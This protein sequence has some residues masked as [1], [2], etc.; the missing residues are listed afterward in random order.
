MTNNTTIAV[1]LGKDITNELLIEQL[2]GYEKMSKYVKDTLA[3]LEND[4]PYDTNCYQFE[5][6]ISFKFGQ[7]QNALLAYRRANN[8]FEVG[9]KVVRY[10]DADKYI[11]TIERITVCKHDSRMTIIDF[12]YPDGF[13]WIRA[14]RLKHATDEEIKANRRLDQ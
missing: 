9:D 8:I 6:G 13:G 5:T 1:D 7:L 14:F 11:L 2:G 3:D 12:N 4:V 10:K